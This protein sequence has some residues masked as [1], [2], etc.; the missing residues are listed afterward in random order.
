MCSTYPFVGSCEGLYPARYTIG[1][2]SIENTV[3][4]SIEYLPVRSRSISFELTDFPEAKKRRFP[5]FS[6]VVYSYQSFLFLVNAGYAKNVTFI[7]FPRRNTNPRNYFP[8]LGG[9]FVVLASYAD[10]PRAPL[11]CP[12]LS[13]FLLTSF[14]SFVRLRGRN[15]EEICSRNSG[16]S[17]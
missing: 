12:L 2:T 5:P 8:D 16:L 14:F 1:G 10:Q 3:P 4:P 15:L 17:E 9:A 13:Q 11:S 6:Q 7:D